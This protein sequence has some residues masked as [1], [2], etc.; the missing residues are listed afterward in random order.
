MEKYIY[1]PSL[2]LQKNPSQRIILF[3]QRQH[4]SN[5]MHSNPH[6]LLVWRG[7]KESSLFVI[8]PHEDLT[9]SVTVWKD[10]WPNTSVNRDYREGVISYCT[11]EEVTGSVALWKHSRPNGGVNRDQRRGVNSYYTTCGGDWFCYC[12]KAFQT[13]LLVWT[14]AKG[15]ALLVITT[16]WEGN[17]FCDC[18]KAIHICC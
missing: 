17:R 13:L 8:T 7:V 12:V 9:G 18:G 6:L 16:T 4:L 11:H 5:K 2:F 1:I 10:S 14:G 15:K 3:S